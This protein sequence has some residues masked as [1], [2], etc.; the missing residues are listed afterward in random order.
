MQPD[1][2]QGQQFT[3]LHLSP[4]SLVTIPA[5]TP[6]LTLSLSRTG[7]DENSNSIIAISHLPIKLYQPFVMIVPAMIFAALESSPDPP[8]EV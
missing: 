2:E 4:T 1:I 6:G 8:I 5:N 3:T 7:T